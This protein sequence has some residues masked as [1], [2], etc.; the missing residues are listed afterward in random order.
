LAE[1]VISIML[2]KQ[3]VIIS[4]EIGKLSGRVESILRLIEPL[5]Y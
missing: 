4:D 1:V 5:Q 2:E 3:V